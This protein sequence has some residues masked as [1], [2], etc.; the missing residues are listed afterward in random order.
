MGFHQNPL[1]DKEMSDLT[2]FRAS[3]SNE[4][5]RVKICPQLH[6]FSPPTN[7][8]IVSIGLGLL[9]KDQHHA[10]AALLKSSTTPSKLASPP[11]DPCWGG[12]TGVD[13]ALCRLPSPSTT[14]PNS[15]IG[16]PCPAGPSMGFARN[17]LMSL[18]PLP[19]QHVAM[20]RKRILSTS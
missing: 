11:L 15:D 19:L 17:S 2:H 4:V 7:I 10:G 3:G 6:Y 12:L 13:E 9:C 5:R 16:D 1:M 14:H 18:G 8:R 20:P